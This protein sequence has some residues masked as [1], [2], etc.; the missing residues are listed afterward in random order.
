MED[1]LRDMTLEELWELFPVVLV[2]HEPEWS[3]WADEEI[4]GLSRLLSDFSPVISH[5]GST[6]IP[7]ICA[8]PIVDILMELPDVNDFHA[9]RLILES[10][11]YI[12]MAHS[13]SK[14]SFNKGYTPEGYAA[15]VFH[16]HVK[17]VGDNDEIIFRDYLLSHPEVACEYERLKLSLLP[18]LRHNRDGYTD[19]KSEFVGRIIHLAKG[20]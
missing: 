4:G 3:V 17:R 1:K 8:K 14:I 10:N 16:V 13:D 11:G 6:A 20:I 15:R 7:G 18:E 2:E 19:A 5:I 9:V 12:C